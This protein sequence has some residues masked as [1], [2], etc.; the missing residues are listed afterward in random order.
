MSQTRW[1]EAGHIAFHRNM[2]TFLWS[3]FNH[4]GREIPAGGGFLPKSILGKS[5]EN[6]RSSQ[7]QGIAC[8][9]DPQESWQ[10]ISKLFWGLSHKKEC[11]MTDLKTDQGK[12]CSVFN[13]YIK[14]FYLHSTID[15]F[16]SNAKQE[17]TNTLQGM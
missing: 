1:A 16:L 13:I 11:S 9:S 12:D 17:A 6:L 2:V 3:Q 10:T 4:Y 15:F 5:Q 14:I 8:D 7:M